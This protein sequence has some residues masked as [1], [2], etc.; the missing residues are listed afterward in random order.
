MYQIYIYIYKKNL[1]KKVRKD[2]IFATIV[3][4][5]N[6]SRVRRTSVH[7]INYW[8]VLIALGLISGERESVSKL[9]IKL[10]NA[11]KESI[12][13]FS[14]FPF[15][16]RLF[17][18]LFRFYISVS[19]LCIPPARK[20]AAKRRPEILSS[21]AIISIIAARAH[22]QAESPLLPSLCAVHREYPRRDD[23]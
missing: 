7:T 12:A 4:K 8:P 14:P 19:S 21:T 6:V 22:D 10:V 5:P 17:R 3:E 11:I 23:E 16:S 15:S 2:N 1:L 9:L 20:C 13:E 18:P